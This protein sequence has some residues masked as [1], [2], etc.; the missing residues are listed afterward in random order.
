MTTI[1]GQLG[2]FIFGKACRLQNCKVYIHIGNKTKSRATEPFTV[3][4]GVLHYTP[5]ALHHTA[6]LKCPLK[7]L[8]NQYGVVPRECNV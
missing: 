7:F 3:K 8:N 4:N 5:G 1:S 6:Y 2:C